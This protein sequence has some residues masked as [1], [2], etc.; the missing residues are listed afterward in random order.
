MRGRDIRV[1]PDD[2]LID[3]VSGQTQ[4]G[5]ERDD[6]GNWFG[7]NNSNPIWHYV[8]NDAYLR[9]NPHATVATTHAQISEVPGAAPVYPASRTLARFNDF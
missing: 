1:Q 2:G 9:R 3:T 5:R 6:Y 7:N 8:L 4:Y